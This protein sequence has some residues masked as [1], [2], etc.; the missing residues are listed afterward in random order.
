VIAVPEEG[1]EGSA[2]AA[3]FDGQRARY[4]CRWGKRGQL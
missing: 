1:C 4:R 2:R 3:L